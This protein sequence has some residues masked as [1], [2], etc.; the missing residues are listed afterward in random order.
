MPFR[1]LWVSF[2]ALLCLHAQ[3]QIGLRE[4]S[5]QG[6]PI[7][8]LYPTAQTNQRLQRGPFEIEAVPNAAPLP[9][10]RRLIVLSH[11]TGGNPWV[12]HGLA[13]TL[14]RAGFVVAQ[15]LHRGSGGSMYTRKARATRE[16]PWRDQGWS[17][18]R[19]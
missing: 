13:A 2:L 9:G 17:T 1:L 3:A 5:S 15:P 18:R 16:A 7:T 6:M 4:L 8:V 12:D 14:V 11:G 10:P 19:P